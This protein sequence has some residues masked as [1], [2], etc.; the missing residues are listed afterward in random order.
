[1]KLSLPQYITD[2][3]GNKLAVVISLPEYENMVKEIEELAIIKGHD[4][5]KAKKEMG[6]SLE[7]FVKSRKV[8]RKS[9]TWC[10]SFWIFDYSKYMTI[11]E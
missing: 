8:N 3:T 1:M 2:S 5:V 10:N 7:E 9:W 4:R 11:P 6:I